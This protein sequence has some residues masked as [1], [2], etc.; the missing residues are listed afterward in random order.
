MSANRGVWLTVFIGSFLLA[1]CGDDHKK[2]GHGK[3]GHDKGGETTAKTHFES[4]SAAVAALEK[5]RAHVEEL[6]E[7]KKF[8][9]LHKAA[10]PIQ[11]IA[12]KLNDLAQKEGSGVSGEELKE[13]KFF[14]KALAK[15]WDKIDKAGDADDLAASKKVYQEIVD[16]INKLKKYGKPVKVAYACAMKCEGEKTYSNPGQCPKCKM[17]LKV[18]V[19]DAGEHHEEEKGHRD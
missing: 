15:T 10:K 6:I 18:V 2:D 1:G 13:V 9:E 16:L 12:E 11:L 4:Y 8:S 3:D 19:A 5:H 14:S 7:H 17:D